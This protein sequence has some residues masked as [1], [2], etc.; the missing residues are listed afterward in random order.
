[1]KMKCWAFAALSACVMFASCS[2]D[3]T[4]SVVTNEGEGT[5]TEAVSA[6]VIAGQS[7]GA[8]GST[9]A[10]ITTAESLESGSVTTLGNGY[11]TDYT[12]ATT[13]VF[14]GN[15]YLYRLAYNYGSA[16]T[17]AAFYLGADGEIKARPREYNILNFTTYG[18]YGNKI[19]TADASSATDTMDEQ[20]NAA[21]GIHFSI[22]DVEAETASTKTLVTEDFLGNK[23]RVMFSGLLEANGK[24]YT[25]VV[26][27]GLSP[28]GV[29][30][31]GVLPGNED[32]VTSTDGG[33]GGGMYVAG[34]LTGTQYPD[35]CWIAIFDDDTFTNPVLVKTDQLS[36]A[37]GR[38]RSAYY[39]T[40]WAADNGDVYVFSPSYAKI[41]DDARQKT[42]L[43]S[44]VMRIKA[45]ATEFDDTYP[46]FNIEEASGGN[47]VYRCWHIADDYF[48]LQMYT[49]GLNIQG[50]GTT[51]MAIFKGESREFRYVTGLPEPDVIS[52]FS[53]APYNEDGMCYITVVTTNEAHP[54]IYKINPETATATPGLTVVADEIGAVGR[55][56]SQ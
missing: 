3:D 47:P 30:A 40:V 42:T 16:G 51:R 44:G 33:T 36:W 22:I 19:I 23:E 21:Y 2:D 50:T 46:V 12:S 34:T 13:W 49:Q 11:E 18:I 56:V 25:A 1:M 15:Q 32:L 26:P 55:L 39:Q 7:S 48:L 4:D 20:G 17:T 5:G 24:I 43:D 9:A 38:M 14:F 53:K 28:Y 29:A 35:E 31:G 10:Y 8:D 54:R 41:Q 45:G 6:Y 52:S 37:S 27:L